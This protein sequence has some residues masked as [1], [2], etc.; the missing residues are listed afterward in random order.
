MSDL[1]VS[2]QSSILE[3]V[4]INGD[5][6]RLTPEQRVNYYRV[7]CESVGLNPL[8]RPFD[9]ITLNGK[10]VLYARREAAEQLRQIY[11][12]SITRLERETINGVYVVTAYARNKEGRMDSSTGAVSVDGL[13]GDACA[14]AMMK[15]ETKAKRRVTLSICGL[16]MLD[17]TETVTIQD[18][19]P[20]TVD[21]E[22]GEIVT[23]PAKVISHEPAPAMTPADE[24]ISY[25]DACKVTNSKGISYGDIPSD[26]LRLMLQ[27][28]LTAIRS[29]G[30]PEE[31]A[32]KKYKRVAIIRIL[33]ERAK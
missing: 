7:V 30:T 26:K 15:A 19:K 11:G 5:L 33:N 6:A 25:E 28:L 12:V 10:M 1:A 17:E 2:N 9:Y 32:A 27:S 23:Q 14:N 22:T 16:G 4:I 29:G 18:A 24:S 31:I 20:V 13:K 3:A 8:T 21:A